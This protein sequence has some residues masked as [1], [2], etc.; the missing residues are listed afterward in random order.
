MKNIQK[1]GG[2][3]AL[4]AGA[5]YIMGMLFFLVIVDYMNVTDPMEKLTLIVNNHTGLYAITMIIYVFFAVFLVLLSLAL[6]E[7]LKEATPLV[8]QTA[9]VFGLIWATILIAS[10]MIFNIGMEKVID[11][12]DKD[13]VQAATVWMSIEAVHEGVGGGNEIVGGIWIL[14]ISIAALQ[15]KTFPRVLNIIGIIVGASG[16]LFTIP[17]LGNIAGMIFGL[18]QII[19]FIW[20]GIFLLRRS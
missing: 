8:I 17:P 13:P 4:Y 20:L 15:L 1:W 7:R 14:L 9:T 6:Y 16:I 12:F 18:I 10:G 5:A 3:S 19:W 11:L 2:I